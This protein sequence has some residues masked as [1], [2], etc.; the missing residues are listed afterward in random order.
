LYFTLATKNLVLLFKTK[1]A[2]KL[3]GRTIMTLRNK[4]FSTQKMAV[5]YVE[6]FFG[7]FTL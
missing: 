3:M 1:Y 4:L 5:I 7:L 6:G 2:K